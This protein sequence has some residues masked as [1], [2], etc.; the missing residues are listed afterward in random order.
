M[1]RRIWCKARTRRC[2]HVALLG[3]LA[4]ALVGCGEPTTSVSGADA[5]ATAPTITPVDVPGLEGCRGLE[6]DVETEADGDR[7]PAFKLPCLTEQRR[8]D[9]SHLGGAPMVVNLWASWCGPCREEMPRLAAA[10]RETPGVRFVGINTRDEPGLAAS[11]LASTGTRYPQL[12]DL[13]GLVL[14]S[15]RVPGLPVTLALDAEGRIVDKVIGEVSDAE[16]DVLLASL[17]EE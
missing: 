16:L 11:F 1:A 10:S 9:T 12:V 3:V 14:D 5:Q 13:D 4:T 17:A 2:S 8:V 6:R 7:L 15:T